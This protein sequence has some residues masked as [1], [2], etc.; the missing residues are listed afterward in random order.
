MAARLA[1]ARLLVERPMTDVF[2]DNGSRVGDGNVV[3]AEVEDVGAGSHREIRAIV[4]GQQCAVASRCGRENAQRHQF[5]LGLERAELALTGRA[6]VT[7]LDDVDSAGQ[8]CLGELREVAFL[9]ARVG[10]Q[11]QPCC[12]QALAPVD[13][14]TGMCGVHGA[15]GSL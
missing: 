14:V 4:D 12:C 8:C 10:A 13:V 9:A 5:V 6:F 2:T 7:Q 1:C 11:V 3:L 15:N